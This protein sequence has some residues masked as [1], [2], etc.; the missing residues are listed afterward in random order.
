MPFINPG[1]MWLVLLLLVGVLIVRGP[2][3]LPEV[4]AGLGRA[5]REFQRTRTE[6]HD[7]LAGVAVTTVDPGPSEER[8]AALHIAG[9]PHPQG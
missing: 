9:E 8:G 2:G 5:I 3:R 1:H 6:V 7:S 4:G